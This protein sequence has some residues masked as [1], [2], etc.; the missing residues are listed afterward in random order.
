MQTR[1]K[2]AEE[3]HQQVVDAAKRRN[4]REKDIEDPAKFARFLVVVEGLGKVA[5]DAAKEDVDPVLVG[6]AMLYYAKCLGQTEAVQ[7]TKPI[8]PE[9]K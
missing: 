6:Q 1:E 4:E 5:L 8:V 9:E 3:F 7:A 2:D